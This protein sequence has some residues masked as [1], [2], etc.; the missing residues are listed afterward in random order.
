MIFMTLYI[1]TEMRKHAPIHCRF[2][3]VLRAKC[4]F[5]G[6]GIPSLA[7]LEPHRANLEPGWIHMLE[8]QLPALLPVATFWNALPEIFHLARGHYCPA[9]ADDGHRRR[10]HAHPRPFYQL[11]LRR[12]RPSHIE[13]IRFSA[14][15]RLL[16][17]N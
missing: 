7:D 14:A 10:R 1:S 12:P 2:L 16:G 6:I 17:G 13:M 11:G 5:K 9:A 15:N 3:E 8:H 4:E